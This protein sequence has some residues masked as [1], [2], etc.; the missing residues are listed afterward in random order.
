MSTS[1]IGPFES[2]W[3][4]GGASIA[5]RWTSAFGEPKFVLISARHFEI[6]F[7]DVISPQTK[8]VSYFALFA[9]RDAWSNGALMSS[10]MTLLP[11]ELRCWQAAEPS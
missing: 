3:H 11:K 7:S 6:D 8:A 5:A 4:P 1:S 9:E 2:A 10:P